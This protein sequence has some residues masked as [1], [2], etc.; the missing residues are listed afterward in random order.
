MSDP[1]ADFDGPW[2]EALDLYFRD[3]IDLF[4]PDIESQIDWSRKQEVADKELQQLA[5][6]A[7][8][9]RGTVDKLVRVYTHRNGPKLVFVHVE[10]QTQN[11]SDFPRRMYEYNHRIEDKYGVMPVSLAILGDY[12]R[13]WR[14]TEYQAGRWGCEVLFKFPVA[15]VADW[16]D[17]EH[18]LEHS[19]NP[20]T[21]FVLAHLKTVETDRSAADRLTWKLRI[22]KRLYDRSLSDTDLLQ[23]YRLIDWMM[24]L[25]PAQA[26]EF[27]TKI[28]AFEEERKMPI[29]TQSEQRWLEKGEA[30]GEARG[31]AKGRLAGIEALLEVRFSADGLALMPRVRQIA[32]PA[33]LDQFLRAAKTAPELDALRALLPPEPQA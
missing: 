12:G 3:F 33:K 17:K 26:D 10:V 24:T 14:P 4:F 11:D 20:L 9:G 15:K 31:E 25:P 2:K 28:A 6:K 23:I 27:D 32:D 18:K 21:G 16:R 5:P 13:G 8:T 30:R 7:V 19:P 22:V 1:A 29:I